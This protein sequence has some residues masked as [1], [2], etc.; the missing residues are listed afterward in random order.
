LKISR[1]GHVKNTCVKFEKMLY[2]AA[3]R[4][5][6]MRRDQ[7]LC[8]CNIEVQGCSQVGGP[9]NPA[10]RGTAVSPDQH[11]ETIHYYSLNADEMRFWSFKNCFK[12]VENTART[13]YITIVDPD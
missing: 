11:N 4:R 2:L 7:T 10:T 9:S 8:L 3:G 12:K 5:K 13:V 1:N 6:G